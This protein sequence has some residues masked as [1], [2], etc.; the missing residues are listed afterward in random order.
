MMD[1]WFRHAVAVG[2]AVGYWRGRPIPQGGHSPACQS[3]NEKAS[4]SVRLTER[5]GR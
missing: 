3:V 4:I 2:E 5:R 1:R